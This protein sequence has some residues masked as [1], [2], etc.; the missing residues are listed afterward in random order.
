M[1]VPCLKIIAISEPALAL[2][3]VLAGGMRGAADTKF[4]MYV[5]AAGSFL[6]RLPLA[7]LLAYTFGLGLV[8]AWAAMTVDILFRGGLILFRYRTGKWKKKAQKFDSV[9]G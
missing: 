4:P 2:N 5:T 6:V 3:M 7:Y 8:G 1:A 9:S